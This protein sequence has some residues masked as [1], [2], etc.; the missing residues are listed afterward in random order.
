MKYIGIKYNTSPEMFVR[1]WMEAYGKNESHEWIAKQL[2]ITANAVRSRGL[3]YRNK[4]VRLPH[5]GR[6]ISKIS[7][8]ALN[9][10]VAKSLL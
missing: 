10:I 5:L 9:K 3:D 8:S 2:G 4:G 6:Q 1:V 7:P